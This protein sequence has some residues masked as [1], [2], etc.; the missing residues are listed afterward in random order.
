MLQLLNRKDDALE[1]CS[2]TMQFSNVIADEDQ[3]LQLYSLISG[4]VFDYMFLFVL[5]SLFDCF[6][7]SNRCQLQGLL[8]TLSTAAGQMMELQPTFSL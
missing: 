6:L 2:S 4:Y 8:T 5:S 3:S 1:W 7:V